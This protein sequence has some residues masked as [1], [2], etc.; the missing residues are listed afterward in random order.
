MMNSK[1]RKIAQRIALNTFLAEYPE[2]KPIGEINDLILKSDDSIGVCDRYEH[3][4]TEDL[5][6]SIHVLWT[7]IYIMLVE[8]VGV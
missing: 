6:D 5:V 4:S 8:E 1:Y 7:D 3:L 2:K